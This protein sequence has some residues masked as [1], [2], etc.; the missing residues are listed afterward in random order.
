MEYLKKYEQWIN[1]SFFDA[2]TQ[3]EL[4]GIKETSEIE[5]RF[6]KELE[7]GT[8]GLRGLMGAGTNRI[9]K[10][11]I[12]KA[13]K[14]LGNYLINTFGISECNERGVTIGYD[15][16]NNSKTYGEIVAGVFSAMGF[17]VYLYSEPRPTPQ[18]SFSVK[19]NNCLAGIVITASHNPK[20]YNG[21]KV[22]DEFGCQLVPEVANEVIK[23]VNEVVDYRTI[24]FD[25]NENNIVTFDDT[26]EF[27]NAVLKQSRFSENN[28]KEDLSIV[29]TPLHGTGYIPITV[30]LEQDGFK[31]VSVVQ[32]QTDENG[33]FPTVSSPN[34]EDRAA[35]TLGIDLAKS[36]DADI[37][38]GTDPDCDRVG[39]AIRVESDKYQLLSGNQIGALLMDYILST[40]NLE[41]YVNP[42]V[43]KTIVTSDL[44]AEIAKK[45]GV[46][47]F[48]TLTGFKF[49]GEKI[50][51]FETAKTNKNPNYDFDFL[52]G[53]EESYG[54][55][56]GSH[57]RDKDAVVSCILICEMAAF[58]KNIGISLVERL[59]EIY[60][61]FGYYLDFLDSITFEGKEGSEQ[62]DKLMYTLRNEPSPFKD[63]ER[64]IDY[65]V[66]V[67]EDILF[68]ALPSSNVLKF[69]LEDESWIA[70]RPSGTEPKIKVYYSIKSS[71]KNSAVVKLESV[72][73]CLMKKLEK[74][75]G[76]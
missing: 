75:V 44:G 65:L 34:P 50:T 5:D 14:G 61:E 17:K 53:Y 76:L 64:K 6:Y 29:Y 25:S 11:T 67:E 47:V 8:G 71:D 54:Y 3:R 62:I 55:L 48:S 26:K 36:V 43:I 60:S 30:G 31:K 21:Y 59:K 18:V 57:S 45:K 38:L 46:N 42:A 52:F 66:G 51:Q 35:L 41:D 10:Y 63:I 49:I 70:I 69:V 1:D 28:S 20:Q 56:T 39:V 13:T 73:Q 22:Y 40:T 23:Y 24:K 72:R 68:G 9:N 33:D 27:V 37:V 12:G 32:K 74:S 4:L 15:T 16:R 7:F 58:Y 2:D 19:R